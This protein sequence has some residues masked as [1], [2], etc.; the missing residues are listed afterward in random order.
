[1]YIYIY[2][3]TNMTLKPNSKVYINTMCTWIGELDTKSSDY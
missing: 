2:T 1:V 3:Y